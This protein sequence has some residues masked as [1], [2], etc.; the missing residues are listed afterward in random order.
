MRYSWFDVHVV[1]YSDSIDVD[2][3]NTNSVNNSVTY[4]IFSVCFFS[5]WLLDICC[6]CSRYSS[7][8]FEL[9]DL[10]CHILSITFLYLTQHINFSYDTC[11]ISLL[12]FFLEPTHYPWNFDHLL[13]RERQQTGQRRKGFVSGWAWP[14]DQ[15]VKDVRLVWWIGI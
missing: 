15:V 8:N 5:I 2:L 1:G 9:C 13:R 6:D 3:E 11:T 4:L 7:C 14:G 12:L 10:L